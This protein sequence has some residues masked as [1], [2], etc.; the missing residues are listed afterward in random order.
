MSQAG[1]NAER[2]KQLQDAIEEEGEKW[3]K[4]GADPSQ[5][6]LNGFL[7]HVRGLATIKV[8]AE[9]LHVDEE[10]MNLIYTR[11]LLS[12]MKDARPM[13]E[14]AIREMRARAI[15]VDPGEMG[16]AKEAQYMVDHL[17]RPIMH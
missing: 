9:L 2:L 11:T 6:S 8:L 3:D 16:A 14:K 12:E 10:E 7:I 17:G 5:I 4:L 13:V 1:T 15:R